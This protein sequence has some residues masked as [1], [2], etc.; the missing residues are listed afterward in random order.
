MVG[1][2]T[3]PAYVEFHILEPPNHTVKTPLEDGQSSK[4]KKQPLLFPTDHKTLGL[5]GSGKD[6]QAKMGFANT[7]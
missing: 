2:K 6:I 4:Q 7:E 3:Y 1:W 5:S